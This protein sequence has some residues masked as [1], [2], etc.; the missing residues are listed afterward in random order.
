MKK[1]ILAF[2]LLLAMVLSSVSAYAAP[3]RFL[4]QDKNSAYHAEHL[5]NHIGS[6]NCK[7]SGDYVK[8]RKTYD[9]DGKL[10]TTTTYQYTSKAY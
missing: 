7:S 2:A 4:K 5:R 6:E 3:A 10:D 8:V 1:K 9:S